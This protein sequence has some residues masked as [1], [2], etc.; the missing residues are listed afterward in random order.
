V[1]AT[2]SADNT[3]DGG[4]SFGLKARLCLHVP[5]SQAMSHHAVDITMIDLLRVGGVTQWMKVA[6]MAEAEPVASP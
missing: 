2:L 5:A 4:R 6:G 1:K 3:D